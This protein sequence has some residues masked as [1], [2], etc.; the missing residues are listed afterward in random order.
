MQRRLRVGRAPAVL[1]V[2]VM[3]III[4]RQ[5][6]GNQIAYPSG[7]TATIHWRHLRRSRCALPPFTSAV[8]TCVIQIEAVRAQFVAIGTTFCLDLDN[9]SRREGRLRSLK[10]AL[11][12]GSF[13]DEERAAILTTLLQREEK[14]AGVAIERKLLSPAEKTLRWSDGFEKRLARSAARLKPGSEASHG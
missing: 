6:F 12:D 1:E 2:R 9:F 10:H 8:T 7:V 11:R 3:R 13:T 14:P 5:I 4:G